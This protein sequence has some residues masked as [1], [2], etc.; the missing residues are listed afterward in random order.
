MTIQARKDNIYH[1]FGVNVEVMDAIRLRDL[2]TE[3]N[4]LADDLEDQETVIE[5]M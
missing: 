5:S 1:D 2:I 3:L 4:Q